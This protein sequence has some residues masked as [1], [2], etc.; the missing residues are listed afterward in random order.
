MYMGTSTAPGGFGWIIPKS[1]DTAN[2]GVGVRTR[3]M[4]SG[5]ARDYL[6]HFV[7][8]HPLAS[9]KLR[10]GTVRTIMADVLPIGGA[11]SKTYSNRLLLVG[12]S[13]GMVMPTNGGGIPTAMVSGHIAGE[14][15]ALHVQ[16]G[17]LLSNYEAR[18]QRAIGREL[19]ASTRMR[20]FA[21]FFMR[22]DRLLDWAM[23]ILNTSGVKK[24]VT[25]KVPSGLD[26]VM[27]L[28]RY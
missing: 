27:R 8:A 20:R 1:P 5:R 3:F 11:V 21:D 9:G 26:L 12:D 24:V 15:A 17:E 14:V 6:D 28:L 23:R 4:K 7:K 25:C 18:W 13:A 19:T 10:S 22:H 2:V 16:R